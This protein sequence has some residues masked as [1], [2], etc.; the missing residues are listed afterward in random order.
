ME[1]TPFAIERLG[2]DYSGMSFRDVSIRNQQREN[3]F[4]NGVDLIDSEIIGSDLSHCE[5]SETLLRGCAIHS[6]NFSSSD[7]IGSIF[8]NCEFVGCDFRTGEWRNARFQSCSFVGC[9]FD[10]TTIAVTCFYECSFDDR[11]MRSM[12]HRAVALN[13]FSNCVLPWLVDDEVFASRNFGVPCVSIQHTQMIQSTGAGLEQLCLLRNLGRM[14]V[15]DLL[16]AVQ[17][18]FQTLATNGRCRTSTFEFMTLIV[19]AVATERKISPTSLILMEELITRFSSGIEDAGM[20]NIAMALV[21]EIRSILF[22]ICASEGTMEH[23]AAE[24]VVD[25]LQLKFAE[26][27]DLDAMEFLVESILTIGYFPPGAIRIEKLEHGSTYVDTV[28]I[29]VVSLGPLLM[30]LNFALRQATITVERVGKLKG[31]VKKVM[32]EPRSTRTRKDQSKTQL[33]KRTH[34]VADGKMDY[35][36]LAATRKVVRHGGIRLAKL[37]IEASVHVVTKPCNLG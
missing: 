4:F 10:R 35:Q 2:N 17:G 37:D 29:A 32:A 19:R 36:E 1:K 18:A 34:A 33:A 23:D 8:E 20:F 6:S 21:I 11:S 14:E 9:D 5:L 24:D 3:S 22:D 27:F 15:I 16:D 7:F 25:R 31:A 13:V 12:I 28:T 30:A 26:T